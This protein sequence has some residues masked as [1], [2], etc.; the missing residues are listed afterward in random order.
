[1]KLFKQSL[2]AVYVFALLVIASQLMQIILYPLLV[3]GELIFEYDN[4]KFAL[5]ISIFLFIGSAVFLGSII[6]MNKGFTKALSVASNYAEIISYKVVWVMIVAYLI[7]GGI[8]IWVYFNELNWKNIVSLIYCLV[9]AFSLGDTYD[10][11][12]ILTKVKR[13]SI[14]NH[15]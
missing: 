4:L 14:F 15:N 11:F 10:R 3:V 12:C 8:A 2:F 5:F 1:M 7:T 13:T 9:Y 6:L